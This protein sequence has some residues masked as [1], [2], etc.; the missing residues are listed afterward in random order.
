MSDHA[1]WVPIRQLTE[2]AQK[3]VTIKGWLYN[4]RKSGKLLFLQVRDGSG[5]VQ[6]VV[7]KK[8]LPEEQFEAAKAMTQETSVIVSGKVNLDD[9]AP[10]G[11]EL[12]VTAVTVVSIAEEYPIRK[13]GTDEDGPGVEFLLNHRHLWLRS[14]RQAAIMRVRHTIVKA[15]RDFLDNDGFYNVDS[16]IFTP[17]ACEGT[18][19]LFSTQY[20]DETVYLSQSG[21]LYNEANAMALGKVYCF[22]PT[23]RAE[24]S[25]TR[26]HLM[27]FWMVEPEMA[28]ATIDDVMDVAERFLAYIVEQCLE[29]NKTD[30]VDE[31]ERDTKLLEAC[32]APLPKMSYDEACDLLAK[33][34]AS[35]ERGD[36]FGAPDEDI[37]SRENDSPVIVHRYPTAVKAFYMKQD[38]VNE[39]RCLGFDV[40]APEGYGE[41][42]GGGQ[43]EE[44]LGVL[45]AAIER[46]G[47]PLEAFDWYLDLRKF[48]SVPHGGF[49][50]GV[51]RTVAWICGLHHVRETIPFPRMLNRNRP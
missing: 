10:G 45:E 1:L 41:I 25:K 12:H 36:D 14:R 7:N 18:T 2:F 26:R 13:V 33:K 28:F 27:E 34:G 4:L 40:L 21:Q 3:E 15:I 24:K 19:T 23:F 43:R 6:C 39:G 47:L 46:H 48:G 37:I 38:P 16:P 32:T 49:G 35:F 42:I 17:N 22:G 44:D 31:L 29:R 50:L 9:R 30:L 11:A 8:D 5:I 20:F 51:E